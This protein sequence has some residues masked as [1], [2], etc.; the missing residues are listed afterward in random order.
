LRPGNGT[1]PKLWDNI[2]GKKAKRNFSK[3]EMVEI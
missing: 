1:S 2:I 3:D